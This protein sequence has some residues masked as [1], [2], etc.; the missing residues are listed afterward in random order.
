[1]GDPSSTTLASSASSAM[2]LPNAQ[3][4]LSGPSLGSLFVRV[5]V[6]TWGIFL[7]PSRRRILCPKSTSDVPS[8]TRGS[9]DSAVTV[10]HRFSAGVGWCTTPSR[11]IG[12]ANETFRAASV[13]WNTMRNVSSRLPAT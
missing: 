8:S 11:R 13:G 2:G 4:R 3:C 7:M 9:F 5:N 6:W 12:I 10:L 1:M